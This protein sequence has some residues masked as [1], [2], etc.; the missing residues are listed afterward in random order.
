MALLSQPAILLL[1]RLPE[2]LTA[3]D[4]LGYDV[5]RRAL[6]ELERSGLVTTDV[7]P[8][9]N[10][11]RGYRPGAKADDIYRQRVRISER[12]RGRLARLRAGRRRR[13]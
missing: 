5:D 10:P 9:P 6:G 1:E 2:T 12:G 4:D 7:W 3:I 13:S 8:P 11:R